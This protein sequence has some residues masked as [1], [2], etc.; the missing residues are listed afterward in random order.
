M[1]KYK[2]VTESTFDDII[3]KSNKPIIAYF[4]TLWAS[5]CKKEEIVLNKIQER[6][7]DDFEYIAINIDECPNIRK[8]YNINIVPTVIFFNNCTVTAKEIGNKSEAI[9]YSHIK[10]LTTY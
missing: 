4:W 2:Y 7:G 3:N 5:D 10:R 1:I 6:F 9:Y 8:E